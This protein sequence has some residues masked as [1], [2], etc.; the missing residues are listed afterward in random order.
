MGTSYKALLR[1]FVITSSAFHLKL[2]SCGK[3]ATAPVILRGNLSGACH[4]YSV[5][6]FL[7]EVYTAIVSSFSSA[8]SL[9]KTSWKGYPYLPAH[10]WVFDIWL[11]AT[12]WS[13]SYGFAA[14]GIPTNKIPKRF[15]RSLHATL[16]SG[17]CVFPEF[18]SLLVGVAYCCL[19]DCQVIRY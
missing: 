9:I 14:K 1:A 7:S 11:S 19:L 13:D 4:D 3:L 8:C 12:L 16:G 2:C 15:S 18:F 6:I 10:F 5:A 17:S